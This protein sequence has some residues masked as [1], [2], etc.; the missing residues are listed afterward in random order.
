MRRFLL[1]FILFAGIGCKQQPPP[2][3]APE[4]PTSNPQEFYKYLLAAMPETLEK[5]TCEC[6]NKSL[7]GCYRDMFDTTKRAKCPFG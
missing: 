3:M 1:A 7:G 2:Y 6:C 4:P 5:V